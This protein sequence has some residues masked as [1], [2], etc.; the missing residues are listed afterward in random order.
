MIRGFTFERALSWPFSA[1]HLT[2]FPWLFGLAYALVSIGVLGAVALLAAN[3]VEAWMRTVEAVR[4]SVDA[5]ESFDTV[6][7]GFVWLLPWAGLLVL[8][9]W[10]VWAMFETASQR[11]YV[12]GQSFSLGFG[13]DELRM[14]VTG[15]LWGLMGAIL[16]AV[17]ALLMLGTAVSVISA[18]ESGLSDEQVAERIVGPMLAATG[19]IFL[20]FPIYVFFATRLAPCFALTLRERKIRFFDAWNVSRRRF[21][22]ILGAYVILAIAGGLIGQVITGLAQFIILPN[23]I[24]YVD[25]SGGG[26]MTATLISPGFLVPM[27]LYLFIAL[28]VQG[29]MQHVVG[30]PAAFAVRHDPRGGV[31]EENQIDAFV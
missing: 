17:P 2:T 28:F 4:G 10:M 16:F 29:V 20:L 23:S 21:W 14:M 19:I 15:L 1:P 31:E 27:G 30:G 7:S 22:P 9:G 5:A 6:F 24:N 18:G 12:F 25:S 8:A 3:D 11:R 13:A 26:D